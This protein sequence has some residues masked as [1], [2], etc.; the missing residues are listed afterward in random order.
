MAVHMELPAALAHFRDDTLRHGIT[1]AEAA[2]V[3]DRLLFSPLPQVLIS[4]CDFVGRQ[5]EA[6]AKI[7]QFSSALIATG[8]HTTINVHPRPT[9]PDDF[10]LAEDEIQ[11]FIVDTWQEFLGV[12][13]I[14]VHDDFFQ[15]GGHSLMGTQVLARLRER[16]K[17]NLSLRVIFDAPTPA[18]LSEHVRPTSWTIISDPVPD[19]PESID[20]VAKKI[21]NAQSP[22]ELVST[23]QLPSTLMAR[24]QRS[25]K[26]PLTHA[27]QGLWLI[28]HFDPGHVGYNIPAGFLVDLPIDRAALQSAVDKLLTRHEILRTSFYEEE[29][30]LFQAITSS[31]PAPLEFTDLSDLPVN[32]QERSLRAL[33]SAEAQKSFNLSQAPLVRFH[34]FRLAERRN[35]IFFCIHHIIAD[36]KSLTILCDELNLLYQAEISNQAASLP[37]LPIQYAD[38]AIWMNQHLADEVMK[39]QFQYWKEKLA[40]LP[41]Y[42]ELSNGRPYPEKRTPWAATTPV[43]ISGSLRDA[44][45][46]IAQQEGA[47]LFMTLLAALAVVLYQ[48]TNAEDFC[49]GSPIT[50]RKQVETESLIGMFVNMLAFRCRLEG[51]PSF[52][53]LLRQVRTTAL[54]AYENSD[55]PFQELVRVLKPVPGSVR[56]PFFQVMFGFDSGTTAQPENLLSIGTAPGMARFDLTLELRDHVDGVVG[57]FEFSTD[58][59][60]EPTAARLARDF[61]R[62]V[63]AA[64]SNPDDPIS[65][66]GILAHAAEGVS[67]G[68]VLPSNGSKSWRKR[69][70][71]F[72]DRLSH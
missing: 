21:P 45:N 35:A 12:E 72:A 54:E 17:V 24:G 69:I 22:S 58:L 71:E 39:R 31:V 32:D 15:L 52:R 50:Y 30:E 4:T 67:I 41:A 44:M 5:R 60:D 68:D 47:T 28:D 48:R 38:Y 51:K 25:G 62:V 43:L 37:P 11:Q 65:E 33:I 23:S 6:V 26:I 20:A 42:L 27:Q 66:L 18:K 1:S 13:P 19:V 64:S 8:T 49:I 14:G 29:G 53:Q 55:V 3:F 63:D 61:V 9:L 36:R 70:Q 57:S 10:A 16:Y 56:P 7:A 34:L 2:D 59:F 40:A 46:N